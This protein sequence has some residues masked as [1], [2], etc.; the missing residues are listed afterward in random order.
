MS[1]LPPLPVPLP[2]LA[3]ASLLVA[4]L[5][6]GL[7]AQTPPAPSGG[8]NG[9]GVLELVERA[10]DERASVVGDSALRSYSAEARGHVYFFMDEEGSDERVL[11]KVDQ[12]ALDVYWKAPNWTKQ[13]IVGLR[14]EKK[15]PTNIHYH[16]DHL[17][18]VLDDFGRVIRLGE[19][20]EVRGVLHPIAPRAPRS[21]DYRLADSLTLTLPGRPEPLRVY[22]VEVRPEDPDDDAFV[23][24]VYLHR[25]TAA[26]V[27]M[28]FT[29]TPSAYVD[30]RLD[31]IRVSLENGLWNG[32]YWLPHRQEV[33]IR[34]KLRF[35]DFPVG[36]VIRGRMR[37]GEYT[38]NPDLPDAMFSAGTVTAHPPERRESFP[39]EEGLYAD[40]EDSELRRDADLQELRSRASGIVRGRILS[41]LRG[42]RLWEPTASDAFRYNRAEG[43]FLGAG[44]TWPAGPGVGVSLHGGRAFG[45]DLTELRGRLRV[46]GGPDASTRID[47]YRDR[48]R[49]VGPIPGSSPAVNT[50][51]ALFFGEDYLD[52]YRASGARIIHRRALGEDWSVAGELRVEDHDDLRRE[53][54]TSPLGDDSFR[55]VRPVA[56]G[57]EGAVELRGR[58]RY[59]RQGLGL[60]VS[61]TLARFDADAPGS[62]HAGFGRLVVGAERRWRWLETGRD[63]T[64]SLDA[65]VAA[66]DVPVQRLFLLGGRGTLPGYPYRSFRGDAFWVVRARASTPVLDPWIS[67]RGFAGAG[68]TAFG[69]SET[70]VHPGGAA[71]D[72]RE[73]PTTG[74]VRTSVGAGIGLL[75]DL[76]HVDVARGLDDGEWETIVEVNRRFWNWL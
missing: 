65:G 9:P 5:P 56:R 28:R 54:E 72:I 37:I 4:A 11:V 41:G 33:E 69:A 47:L 57:R 50:L 40:L 18:V 61:G 58:R 74:G 38:F 55:P 15:L 67:L 23:G 36:G 49:D 34:R 25:A 8:W 1:R 45:A 46:D 71:P 29:F 32:R 12:I 73:I 6:G 64:L 44:L 31:Y 21:Y 13:V 48:L 24:S 76:L 10:I 43:L 16:L 17:T 66:G 60:S 7:T 20:D 14:D 22:E 63:V 27:R 42:L 68:A 70:V 35:V 62:G 19:G 59:E 53:A 52:P 39:F 2:T 26:I 30:P 3:A 75:F 51:A